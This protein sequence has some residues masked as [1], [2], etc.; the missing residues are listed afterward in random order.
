MAGKDETGIKE[1]EL[2]VIIHTPD[3]IKAES[4]ANHIVAPGEEGDIMILPE[5]C[6]LVVPL[7]VGVLH[8]H[9]PDEVEYYAV[10]GGT[11]SVEND[12]VSVSA[13]SAEHGDDIDKER[14]ER[15]RERA[16]AVLDSETE[17]H[18][19]KEAQAALYRA[20]IRLEIHELANSK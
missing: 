8:L 19:I 7:R 9:H 11:L 14:A 2:K 6:G 10:S 3:G 16:E 17:D 18:I 4:M 13:F 5:H 1:E 15:A 20:L 12:I